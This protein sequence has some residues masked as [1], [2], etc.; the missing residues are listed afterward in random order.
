MSGFAL[1]IASC[2]NSIRVAQSLAWVVILVGF[3]F[4]AT[5]TIANSSLLQIV[6]LSWLPGWLDG[7][8]RGE[9]ALL[10]TTIL[11]NILW[12]YP[13]FHVVRNFFCYSFCVAWSYARS[14]DHGHDACGVGQAKGYHDIAAYA[15]YNFDFV[16]QT[17]VAK[18][19]CA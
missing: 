19:D 9:A 16:S 8:E 6:Y 5:L 11:R 1:G 4:Q 2:V 3:I 17:Y 13:P 7:D 10:T 14:P 18:T 12:I 15:A